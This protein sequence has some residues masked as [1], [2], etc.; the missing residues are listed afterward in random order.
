LTHTL[1]FKYKAGVTDPTNSLNMSNSNVA[2]ALSQFLW[3]FVLN[4]N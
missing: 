1:D 3:E 2:K 4:I